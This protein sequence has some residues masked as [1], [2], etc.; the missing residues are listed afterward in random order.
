MGDEISF[1]FPERKKR[2]RIDPSWLKEQLLAGVSVAKI[3]KMTGYSRQAVN[4][5]VY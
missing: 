4:L 5:G 3:A 2:S 1:G